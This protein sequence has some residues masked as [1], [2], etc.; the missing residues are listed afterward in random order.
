MRRISF[1][2]GV[3]L[4]VGLLIY[5]VPAI[6]IF[7]H[8]NRDTARAS[9]AVLVLVARAYI[10]GRVNPCLAGRVRQGVKLV[11]NGSAKYLIVSGGRD[12]EDGRLESEAMAKLAVSYGLLPGQVIQEPKAT[13]TYQ[14][15]LY[16]R[17]IMR[18]RG[19]NTVIIVSQAFHLPRAALTAEKLGLRF[20]VSPVVSDPCPASLLARAYLREP[21]A[22]LAYWL[23]GRG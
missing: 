12:V 19:W 14:N 3:L 10:D 5:A 17:E 20:T 2:I 6:Y 9:N 8:A 11:Q 4:V 16:S 7:S 1:W 23:L 21:V 13:S 22:L 18:A 15:L